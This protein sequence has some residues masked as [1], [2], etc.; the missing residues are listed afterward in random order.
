[1]QGPRC[2]NDVNECSQFALAGIGCQNGGTCTNTDG[3]F[4]FVKTFLIFI[5]LL[6]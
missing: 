6:I 4:R 1:M 2:E 3:G 5:S